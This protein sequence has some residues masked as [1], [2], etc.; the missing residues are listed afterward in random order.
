M[1][2]YYRNAEKMGFKVKDVVLWYHED[3]FSFEALLAKNVDV[4]LRVE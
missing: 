2:G 1:L 3:L 4:V